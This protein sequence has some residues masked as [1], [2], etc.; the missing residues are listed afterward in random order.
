M[1]ALFRATAVVLTTG[2]AALSAAA[3]EPLR[4][5]TPED[6]VRIAYVSGRRSRTAATASRSS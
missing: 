3:T 6:I 4:P 5:T 1:K 2:F